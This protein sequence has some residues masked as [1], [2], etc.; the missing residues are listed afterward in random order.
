MI[1][2]KIP[3]TDPRW[4]LGKQWNGKR[5]PN[6]GR[7]PVYRVLHLHNNRVLVVQGK[8][9][10]VVFGDRSIRPA[11]I[12]LMRFMERQVDRGVALLA[13]EATDEARTA[14]LTA[15]GSS[16][17]KEP[18]ETWIKAWDNVLKNWMEPRKNGDWHIQPGVIVTVEEGYKALRRYP[19]GH[20]KAGQQLPGAKPGKQGKRRA[21][22]TEEA[23]EGDEV[24]ETPAAVP[25]VNSSA[26]L[27]TL[28]FKGGNLWYSVPISA[29]LERADVRGLAAPLATLKDGVLTCVWLVASPEG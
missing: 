5:G 26:P 16:F 18:L 1:K 29:I 3:P 2:K 27:G 9:R 23:E 21:V 4:L 19:P 7:V 17:R 28:G 8:Y 14:F 6:G 10:Q 22:A 12:V 15:G 25:T 11:G 24:E 13:A 20:A